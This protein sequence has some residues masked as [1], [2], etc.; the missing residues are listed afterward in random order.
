[1]RTKEEILEAIR[2][3]LSALRRDYGVDRIALFGSYARGEQSERSDLDLLVEFSEP[4]DLFEFIG[5]ELHLTDLLGI[6]VDLVTPDAL[7]PLMRDSV[8]GSAL[9]A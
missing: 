6:K 4:V 2:V 5:L 9:Y 3:E 1:M 7:R 8:L